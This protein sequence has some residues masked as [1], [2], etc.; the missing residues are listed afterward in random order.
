MQRDSDSPDVHALLDSRYLGLEPLHNVFVK[1]FIVQLWRLPLVSE[2]LGVYSLNGWYVNRVEVLGIVVRR[3]VKAGRFM[4]VVDDSS[5]LVEVL[6]WEKRFEREQPVDWDAIQLGEHIRVRGKLSCYLGNPQLTL[7]SFDLLPEGSDGLVEEV[8][9][10]KMIA[11]LNETAY[12]QIP[13]LTDGAEALREEQAMLHRVLDRKSAPVS[14]LECI[15][16]VFVCLSERETM[17]E[18]NLRLE[19]CADAQLLRSALITLCDNGG[20]FWEPGKVATVT[21]IR[22]EGNLAE[23]I[24][25]LIKSNGLSGILLSD[26]VETLQ[27]HDR[28]RCVRPDLIEAAMEHLSTE[29]R[30]F[31]DGEGLLKLV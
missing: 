20:A 2:A 17:T 18:E 24:F 26:L 13:T 3:D 16:A 31:N 11:E 12:A 8:E 23:A 29:S 9:Q 28:W 22:P 21:Q 6:V 1:V 10:W 7:S 4:F 15:G 30:I 19:L 5:G 14:E 25:N 27:E